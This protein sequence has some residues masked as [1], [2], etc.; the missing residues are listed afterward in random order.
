[1]PNEDW[2]IPDRKA[3]GAIPLSLSPTIAFNISKATTVVNLISTLDKLYEKP[4]T[5][6]KVFL[7]KQLFK[8]KMAKGSSV[9][10]HLNDFNTVTSQLSSLKVVFDDEIRA[11]LILSSLPESWNSLVMAISNSIFGS[12][13]LK[14]DD[15]VGV[16]LSEEMRRKS[17][18]ETSTSDNV[19]S[20]DDKGRSKER[21]KNPSDQEKSQGRSKSK[22]REIGW[23]YCGKQ[24]YIK[25]N[26][27]S[28]KEAK[29][30]PKEDEVN[31][32]Y[33]DSG[34]LI[35]T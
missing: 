4:S 3:L 28:F 29:S 20:V 15:V 10:N 11:L 23:W 34:V 8:M 7:M 22:G 33:E 18:N 13:T 14:F 9:V 12:N 26:C 16:I 6:N 21:G 24:S 32:V 35:L 27:W 30:Q 25:K 31:V 2:N 17:T 5:S 1:M 19:L